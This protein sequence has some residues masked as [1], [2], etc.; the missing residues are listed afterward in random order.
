MHGTRSRHQNRVVLHVR[1]FPLAH[2]GEIGN[3]GAQR[4]R[5]VLP[6][7]GIRPHVGGGA[8]IDGNQRAKIGPPQRN[9]L[10]RALVVFGE[11][12]GADSLPNQRLLDGLLLDPA[13]RG[14][15]G[16]GPGF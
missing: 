3:Q 13:E 11:P 6:P 4:A 14:N 5:E 7:A 8:S 12:N 15:R 10:Q 16:S 9:A 2:R 1:L